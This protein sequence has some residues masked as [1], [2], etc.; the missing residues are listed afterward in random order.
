[1]KTCVFRNTEATYLFK[2]KS[3][4]TNRY[5]L[6]IDEN[7]FLLKNALFR[8]ASNY[9]KITETQPLPT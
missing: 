3:N 6:R 5:Q 2:N 1:M 8:K 4:K 7:I 9:F